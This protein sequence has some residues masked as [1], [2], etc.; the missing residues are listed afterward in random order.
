LALSE[1]ELK[2]CQKLMDQFLVRKRPPVH[3]RKEFDIGY[4]IQNQSVVI[5]EIR[6][7][8]KNPSELMEHPVAKTTYVK[9]QGVW[10]VYWMRADLKWHSYKPRPGVKLLEGFLEEVLLDQFG[11][12]WG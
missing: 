11:C 12:F 9:S 8:W 10:K 2:R 3:I 6:P 1:F 5:F 4:R 7:V